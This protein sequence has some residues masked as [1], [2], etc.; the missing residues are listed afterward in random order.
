MLL[1]EMTDKIHC[2][3]VGS[4][5]VEISGMNYDSRQVDK[6]DL[7]FCIKGYETDGHKY[8][9]MAVERGAV[10]IVVSELQ[11]VPVTQVVVED[12]RRA[13]AEMSA[14]FYGEPAK[15]LRM[16]GVTGTN[17]K[18]SITYMI[19]NILE[20][21]GEKV[22]LLGTIVNLIG[23]RAIHT[24]R[25]TPES[26]DLQRLLRQMVDEGVNSVVMEVSSHSLVLERVYGIKFAAAA[27]TNL[28]QDHLDFHKTFENYAAAKAILFQNSEN[29]VINTD[30]RYGGYMKDA[31]TGRVITYGMNKGDVRAENVELHIDGCAYKL[32][33]KDGTTFPIHV[34]I[35]G[36]F[37]VYNTL[38]AAAVAMCMG[39]GAEH[40]AAGIGRMKSVPG[41]FE[42]LNT[43]GGGYTVIL[44]YAH[45]PDSLQSTLQTIRGF[46]KGRIV[47]IVG[48]G[49]NRDSRKRPI[50]G[51][52]TGRMADFS[53]ITSDNPRFEKPMDIIDMIIPGVEKSGG[54]Y[55]VIENRR[56]AI[57]YALEHAKK[58]DVILLAG[59]GHEDYQE[60]E[61]VKHPFDEK[62][63]V[64]E[65]LSELG[66]IG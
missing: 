31:A 9:K 28:T 22:G 48:C 62:V 27:F 7:F 14:F 38:C 13:M 57:R 16:I 17:G 51:E 49:G 4:T 63:I 45:T 60:I 21:A 47:S 26:M 64:E 11:D 37:S 39:I 8:A 34:A 58:D 61:G 41:R 24:E 2:R 55:I 54:D 35:P 23:D 42:A 30:D 15:R 66:R 46:A 53:I 29:A 33:G 52:I 6:G 65:L 12:G 5:D 19:K 3:V 50:M 36:M 25:T 56:N 44:D 1:K 59:K 10:C 40:I 18:T 32:V 20:T 43:H